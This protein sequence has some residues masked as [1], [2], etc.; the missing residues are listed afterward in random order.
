MKH[1]NSGAMRRAALSTL[2]AIF[3]LSPAALHAQDEVEP[4]PANTEDFDALPSWYIGVLGGYVAPD[5]ARD[6]EYGLNLH[7]ILGF[8]LDDS[9]ALELNAFGTE[10][11]R[12]T[13][14]LNDYSYGAGMDL[15]LGTLAPGHPFFMIGG[16]VIHEELRTATRSGAAVVG[17][18]DNVGYAN[19]GLGYYLPFSFFGE[20]WRLEG[21]YNVVFND[22]VVHPGR[23]T[24]EN[25]DED[26][27][28][29]LGFLFAFGRTPA[30]A[31]EVQQAAAIPPPPPP[32]PP[33][34]ASDADEDGV[35]DELDQC[36]GTPR[37]VR[38]DANGCT[39]DSDGD[40]VDETRDCCPNT[41]VGTAVDGQGCEPPPPPPP[42]PASLAPAP[43]PD[44]DNDGVVDRLDECPNTVAGYEVAA[45]GCVKIENVVVE[46]VHFEVDSEALTPEA[47]RLLNSVAASFKRQMGTVVEVAGHADSTGSPAYNMTL[48]QRR[49]AVVRDFLIYLGVRSDQLVA[50]GYGDTRPL[51]DN[52]TEEGRAKNRRVEFRMLGK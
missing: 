20:L 50:A 42:P 39:P 33:P 6:S 22:E 26:G 17:Y 27:R 21:R 5:S 45:N 49:A 14:G 7:A 9:L 15:T 44:A 43:E 37:W 29:N 51:A 36:P 8:V 28:F 13:D 41:P 40:G 1:V 3:L 4:A 25:F 18:E 34:P 38:A 10:A 2:L 48:S 46:S 16:G 31:S 19:A 35:A 24:T 52:N 47:Y 12:E 11:Q 30:A 23:S 32:P